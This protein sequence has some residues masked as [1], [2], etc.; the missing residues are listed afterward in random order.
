MTE[1]SD[2]FAGNIHREKL[3]IQDDHERVHDVTG[4][5]TRLSFFGQMERLP[6]HL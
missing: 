1:R 2:A 4:E 5:L 6:E 3:K